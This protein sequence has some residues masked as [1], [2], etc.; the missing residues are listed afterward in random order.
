MLYVECP[1]VELSPVVVLDSRPVKGDTINKLKQKSNFINEKIH[2]DG[3]G[4]L[5][6]K[7]LGPGGRLR[8][9]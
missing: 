5:Q 1:S 3:Q 8:L 9:E 7:S 2:L 4:R 6:V